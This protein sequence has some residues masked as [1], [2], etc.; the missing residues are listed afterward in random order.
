LLEPSR[1]YHHASPRRSF[2]D[3]KRQRLEN[4]VDKIAIGI[5]VVAAAKNERKREDDERA[6]EHELRRQ[7]EE[8]TARL[9]FIEQR[10]SSEFGSLLTNYQKLE[11]METILE[12]IQ[13]NGPIT[14]NTRLREFVQWLSNQIAET[15]DKLALPAIEIHF[16]ANNIFGQNDDRDIRKG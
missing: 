12:H 8:Q 7:R 9:K 2:N 13:A 5:A 1:Y 4:I 16:C 14:P 3:G 10:R 6:R 15:R 11:Q